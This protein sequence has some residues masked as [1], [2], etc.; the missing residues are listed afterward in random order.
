MNIAHDY[1]LS[2]DQVSRPDESKFKRNIRKRTLS[3]TNAHNDLAELRVHRTVRNTNKYQIYK[4][5][6]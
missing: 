4:N 1:Y 5:T 2:V 3:S 6:K